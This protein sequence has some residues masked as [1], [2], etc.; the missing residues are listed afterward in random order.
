MDLPLS[1]QSSVDYSFPK[2]YLS[3]LDS[4]PINQIALNIVFLEI[5]TSGKFWRWMTSRTLPQEKIDKYT[6]NKYHIFIDGLNQCSYR[7]V[8]KTLIKKYRAVRILVDI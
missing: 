6:R 8:K 1:K 3:K 5:T 2:G 7:V 4:V